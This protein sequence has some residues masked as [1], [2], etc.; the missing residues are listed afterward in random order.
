MKFVD[1]LM[2]HRS[3]NSQRFS[4]R[5]SLEAQSVSGLLS[6]LLSVLVT[7][8]MLV[9]VMMLVTMEMVKEMVILMVIVRPGRVPQRY[10]VLR[11]GIHCTAEAASLHFTTF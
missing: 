10:D 8:M 11:Q 3:R 2:I 4:P 7:T 1:G 6:T 9:T 5:R